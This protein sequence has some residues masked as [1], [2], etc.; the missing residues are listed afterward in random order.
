M[1]KES[2]TTMKEIAEAMCH[3]LCSCDKC[4]KMLA[5]WVFELCTSLI[6]ANTN[7]LNR[8]NIFLE[9]ANEVR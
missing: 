3:P 4:E 8:N 6:V 1:L 2:V 5:R 7:S 9:F